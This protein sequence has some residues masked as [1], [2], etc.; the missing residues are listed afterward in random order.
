M[1]NWKL[2]NYCTQEYKWTFLNWTWKVH[3]KTTLVYENSFEEK[4]TEVKQLGVSFHFVQL[5]FCATEKH[6][7]STKDDCI[8]KVQVTEVRGSSLGKKIEDI[9]FNKIFCSFQIELFDLF[10]YRTSKLTSFSRQS[11]TFRICAPNFKC[12]LS[13]LLDL[14]PIPIH[15][16]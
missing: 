7:A 6:N 2:K 10:R 1:L 5:S 16:H 15:A 13:S 8:V 3:F 11:Y 14:G 12:R 4:D 9:D